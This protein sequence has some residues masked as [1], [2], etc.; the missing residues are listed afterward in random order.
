LLN[1]K[2]KPYIRIYGFPDYQVLGLG[3]SYEN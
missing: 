1:I 2:G 3:E